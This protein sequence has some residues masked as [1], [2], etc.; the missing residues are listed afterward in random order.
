[1]SHDCNN[2]W[3]TQAGYIWSMIGSAVGFANILSFSAHAYKNGGG[4]FLIP[5]FFALLALGIPFL[6]LEGWI[7]KRYQA[8]LV[9]AYAQAM[10]ERGKFLG[11]LS[12]IACFTIGAFYIVLTGYSVAYVFFAASGAIP[13]DTKTFFFRDFLH[14]TGGLSEWGGFSVAIF[15]STVI[16]STVSY[17]VLARNVKDGVEKISLIFMPLLFVIMCLFAVTALSLPGGFEGMGYF[18][19]PDFSRLQ[20]PA[21]WRDIFGQLFFSLSLGLGIIVGYSRHA[22]ES[23]NIVKAMFL[24][25]MGD[26][27]VSFVS[28]VAIFG[29]LSHISQTTHVPFG[30]IMSSDSI[31]DI[32]FVLFPKILHTFGPVIS[33]V[34]GTIFFFSVFIAGITGVFSIIES[35]AGNVE[36]AFSISRRAAVAFVA[37]SMTMLSVFFC[38]GNGIFVIDAIAPMVLGTSM[39]IAALCQVLVFVFF[40]KEFKEDFGPSQAGGLAYFKF[41]IKTLSPCLITLILACNLLEEI[42][43]GG[44]SYMVRWVWLIAAVAMSWGLSKV[45][46]RTSFA[47]AV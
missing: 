34:A 6:I 21:L 28:G 22:K 31:F 42:G 12:V 3:R 32:G 13:E 47:E 20:D 45:K 43:G 4:A 41:C 7:G 38:M 36:E 2:T 19:T 29:F 9:T 17:F 39:L 46:P 27:F 37:A 8:S 33:A 18:L 26:F 24:V 44:E 11:W 25:A 10:G 14:A 15:V 30:E 5:Y 16:V 40:S 1:M 23:Q 35:I